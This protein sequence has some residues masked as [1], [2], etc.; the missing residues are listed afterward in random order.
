MVV[1]CPAP[2]GA[3]PET[4]FG[5][6]SLCGGFFFWWGSAPDP[7]SSLAGARRPAPLR[8]LAGALP[9]TPARRLRVAPRRF[10]LAG[11]LPQTPARRLRGPVAPRRSSRARTCAPWGLAV[12]GE[13]PASHRDRRWTRRTR[14]EEGEYRQYSTPGRN[15]PAQILAGFS[16][17]RMQRDF[18]HG[19]LVSCLRSSFAESAL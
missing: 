18:Y 9:Q 12:R 3:G 19:L 11:A 2:S 4:E 1:A 14:R 7:G 8:L 6:S 13:S 15:G 10:L 16:V 17:G 5:L